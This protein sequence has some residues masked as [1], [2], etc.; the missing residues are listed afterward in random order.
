MNIT[1]IATTSTEQM[2]TRE[3]ALNFGGK[4]AGV[5]YMA[6]SLFDIMSE[7]PIKTKKRIERTL[8]SGHHS[9][10]EHAYFSVYL[11]G[12]PKILA[13]I[14][15]NE[16]AY[17]TSEKS[18]R[19]T[20]MQTAGKEAELYEKWIDIFKQVIQEQYA[21]IPESKV[22]SLAKENARYLISVFTPST[23]M[24]YTTSLRQWNYILHWCADYI[25][26]QPENTPFVVKVKCVLRE[27][28]KQMSWIY[29]RALD[30]KPRTKK[31]SLF[32]AKKP[33][34][35]QFGECYCTTY[36]GSF[37]QLAQ[38]QRHRT[39]SYQMFLDEKA[40][41]KYYVPPI[42]EGTKYKKQWLEDIGQLSD[43]YPQGRLI[44]ICERG[45][46]E[47]FILKCEER[48]CGQAQL[49]IM[50][51]T[52]ATLKDYLMNLARNCDMAI[53][54]ELRPYAEGTRCNLPNWVCKEPCSFGKKAIQ[55]KI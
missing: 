52:Y 54:N 30:I 5:C 27:F 26:N 49:E 32:A 18:A 24:V 45:L 55:R 7:D 42:I 3:Q 8:Y 14:L 31:L 50:N 21:N 20:K 40:T 6:N 13:M 23:N 4:A 19:Y 16:R 29:V 41:P 33:H 22:N 1:V 25:D 43:N 37:A 48:L 35:E 36:M 11:E 2:M 47:N 10:Y 9:V 39:I 44:S 12:I 15:N 51:Q 17:V 53:Y 38:A 46:Y 28:V 34:K